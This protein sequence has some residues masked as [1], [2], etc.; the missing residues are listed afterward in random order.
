MAH[1][2]CR[3]NWHAAIFP[4]LYFSLFPIKQIWSCLVKY[5]M[6]PTIRSLRFCLCVWFVSCWNWPFFFISWKAEPN[7]LLASSHAAFNMQLSKRVSGEFFL[8]L[9][10][11]L[12]SLLHVHESQW[13]IPALLVASLCMSSSSSFWGSFKVENHI[14]LRVELSKE[15]RTIWLFNEVSL[16]R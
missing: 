12:A 16:H 15:P 7:L 10:A 13:V 3:N 9:W 6:S 14:F 1:F 4:F 2:K 5:L 8:N 11:G